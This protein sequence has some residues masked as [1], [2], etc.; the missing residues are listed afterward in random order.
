MESVQIQPDLGDC[1]FR[2]GDVSGPAQQP[3]T[4]LSP[5]P[6]STQV[7]K[8][9]LAAAHAYSSRASFDT[10]SF[11]LLLGIFCMGFGLHQKVNDDD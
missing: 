4:Q 3:G 8:L 2:G 10:F 11:D 6:L 5:A 1:L 7:T 9:S